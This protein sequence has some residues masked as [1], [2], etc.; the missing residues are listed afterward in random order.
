MR[1]LNYNTTEIKVNSKPIK[2]NLSKMKTLLA[3]IILLIL[4]ISVRIYLF[5]YKKV[6]TDE[7]LKDD[8]HS[9]TI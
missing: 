6:S 9:Y 2:N 1:S 7:L 5:Y 4:L 8:T 3:I